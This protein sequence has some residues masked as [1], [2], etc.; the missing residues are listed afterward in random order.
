MSLPW[1][2]N[3]LYPDGGRAVPQIHV[4]IPQILMEQVKD[5]SPVLDTRM[6][7]D[8]P[9]LTLRE[10]TGLRECDHFVRMVVTA[11]KGK[12][13]ELLQP[14]LGSHLVWVALGRTSWRSGREHL[15]EWHIKFNKIKENRGRLGVARI[16]WGWK[17]LTYNLKGG[18]GDMSG[19]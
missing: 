6:C 2:S 12:Y 11:V 17:A 10:F 15:S 16:S 9:V 3:L 7:Q 19:I 18:S 1:N 14:V 5:G 13:W 8:N 4:F